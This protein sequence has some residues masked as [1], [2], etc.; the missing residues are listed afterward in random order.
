[1]LVLDVVFDGFVILGCVLGFFTAYER[2][3]L[4]MLDKKR[5][6]R[7]Y[8]RTGFFLALVTCL[9]FNVLWLDPRQ[10]GFQLLRL[11][12]ILGILQVFRKL[13]RKAKESSEN[14]GRLNLFSLLCA[15]LLFSHWIACVPLSSQPHTAP[16]LRHTY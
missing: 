13:H 16:G 3:G 9:P 10:S 12:R 5:V 4:L 2:R 1:L 6:K 7:H 8:L 14:S 11:N 15:F